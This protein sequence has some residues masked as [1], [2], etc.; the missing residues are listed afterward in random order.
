MALLSNI[1]FGRRVILPFDGG[2]RLLGGRPGQGGVSFENDLNGSRD[3]RVAEPPPADG[4]GG[5]AEKMRHFVPSGR[6]V[7]AAS[8]K[9]APID[10]KVE[11]GGQHD[12]PKYDGRMTACLSCRGP[13]L[14]RYR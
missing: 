13:Q 7:A 4:V 6:S 2:E 14:A 12:G 5:D 11:A 9:F 8:H 3:G 1:A 10:Q